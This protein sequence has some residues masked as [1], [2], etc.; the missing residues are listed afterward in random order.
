MMKYLFFLLFS[1]AVSN[2]VQ[3]QYAEPCKEVP[4]LNQQIIDLLTPFLGK[5]IDRG[6]CWD[7]AKLAL[8]SVGA[9]WD[10]LYAFGRVVNV[11]TECIQPGDIVQFEQV[12]IEVR[13]G[14]S[15]YTET[16]EHHTAIVYKVNG[17]GNVELIHQNTGQFGRKMGI[18][19]LNLAHIKKGTITFFR[20]VA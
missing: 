2:G 17:P 16:F 4:A 11:K 20:P 13:E 12:F 7:A 15:G 19:T 18:T 10:G 8:N 1:I 5:K 3:A 14:N 9:E 6:E